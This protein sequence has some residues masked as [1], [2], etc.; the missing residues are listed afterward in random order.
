MKATLPHQLSES[1][2]FYPVLVWVV[3]VAVAVF[4]YWPGLRGPF[5]FDDYGSIAALGDFGGVRDWETFKAFVFG[6]HSGPTGRPLA[7]FSFLLD[8]TNWPADS[9]GFKRTNLIIHLVTATLLAIL[10]RNILVVAGHAERRA[11]RVAL[12]AAGLWLLH[13][14]LVSTTL[15]AVQRMAQLSAM[16]VLAGLV[17]HLHLRSSDAASS[18]RSQLKMGFSLTLFTLLAM[19]CKENGILLPVLVGVLELTIL[20]RLETPYPKPGRVWM[21]LFVL[22][23][24]FVIFAYLGERVMRPNFFDIVPPRDFS[25]YERVISQPR[26]LSEYL[27]HWYV[28]KLFT[29]G[30]FQDHFI[31]STGLLSPISTLV[32]II[33]HATI[34]VL[35]LLVRKRHALFSLA[36][37][38]FYASHLLESTVINLELYFEHRNYLAAAFLFLPIVVFIEKRIENRAVIVLVAVL[39]LATLTSFTRY[40]AT[41]WSSYAGMVEVAAQKA[42]DS[43]RAQAQ[44][45]TDLY[46]RGQYDEALAVLDRAVERVPRNAFLLLTRSNILCQLGVLSAID[47]DSMADI[48]SKGAFDSRSISIYQPLVDSVVSATCPDVSN[49]AI[50]SMFVRM[51]SVDV[52]AE[53]SSL[54]Y[55]QINYFIGLINAK[56][57]RPDEAMAAFRQSLMAR[58][59]AGHAMLMAAVM[60]TENYYK[61]ALSLSDLAL[62]RLSGEDLDGLAREGVRKS[63]IQEFQR[64]LKQEMRSTS[65]SEG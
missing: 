21:T 11:V 15:Y 42:P 45:A 34:L 28:P 36:V 19:L 31:K 17:V 55:S 24:A 65:V 27:Y 50:G 10:T 33:I 49:D 9:F 46:N 30:V 7:L 8:A 41:I 3:L 32:G 60:A 20:S 64:N 51:L 23:P 63:D 25:I 43:A 62:Q 58:P 57:D 12:F 54:A 1:T 29:A 22:V 38:F 5:L 52:N 37:L 40:S 35:A 48:V 39:S 61:D 18:V 16:F 13:P 4:A 47:F 6:G 2:K 59:G 44:F 26:A 53:P 14:F 56:S